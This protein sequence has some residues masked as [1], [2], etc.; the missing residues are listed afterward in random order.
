MAKYF[1]PREFECKCGCGLNNMDPKLVALLDI[2]R[3][4]AGPPPGTPLLITS[5]CRCRAHNKAEGGSPTSSHLTGHAVDIR[6]YSDAT[7]FKIIASALLHGVNRIG[8]A[9]TYIHLDNDPTKTPN[10]MWVYS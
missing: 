7:R 1:Q 5:G 10:V 4:H 6:A 8:I 2:I 9:R 3:E